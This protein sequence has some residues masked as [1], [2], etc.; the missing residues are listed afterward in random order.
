MQRLELELP[1]HYDPKGELAAAYDPPAMPA[2]YLLNRG[3]VHAFWEG[4]L[5]A[6]ALV[7]IEAVLRELAP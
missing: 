5:D 4:G 7:A 6:D 1:V 2:T 3:N